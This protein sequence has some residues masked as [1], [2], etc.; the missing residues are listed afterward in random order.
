MSMRSTD[1]ERKELLLN[2]ALSYFFSN[3]ADANKAFGTDYTDEEVSEVHAQVDAA[4]KA[5]KETASELQ[6]ARQ[7]IADAQALAD[8]ILKKVDV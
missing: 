2:H 8:K 3:L 1:P 6:D 7:N 4:L 5:A